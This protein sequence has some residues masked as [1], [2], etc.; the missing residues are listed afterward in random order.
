MAVSRW[1]MAGGVGAR[2][3]NTINKHSHHIKERERYI[4]REGERERERERFFVFV[5]CERGLTR[6][7]NYSKM[8]IKIKKING[9]RMF[10]RTQR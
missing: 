1:Q 8:K 6:R 9:P 4:E 3:D 5:V 2:D 10:G 7:Q